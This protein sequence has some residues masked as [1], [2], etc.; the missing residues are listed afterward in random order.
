M[1][2]ITTDIFSGRRN[3][4]YY[5]ADAEAR[6]LLR[7][8]GRRRGAIT[9]PTHGFDGLGF[10]GVLVEALSDVASELGP[11]MPDSFR[12]GGGSAMD[13]GNGL[14]LAERLIRGL[15]NHEPAIESPTSR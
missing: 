14:D 1:L 5:L 7:D 12:V 10:R 13:E 3:P 8:V 4:A 11:E 15:T 2:R 9:D 6:A